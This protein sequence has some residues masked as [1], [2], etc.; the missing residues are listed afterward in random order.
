MVTQGTFCSDSPRREEFMEERGRKRGLDNVAWGLPLRSPRIMRV[1]TGHHTRYEV[2]KRGRRACDLP[3]LL[4]AVTLWIL[5]V[6]PSEARA[7]SLQERIQ[8]Q[9]AIER[10]YHAHQIDDTR[11]FEEAVPRAV[12]ERKVR[13]YLEHSIALD[14]FW[15]SPITSAMLRHEGANGGSDTHARAAS[16]APSGTHTRSSQ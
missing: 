5:A 13:T 9:E 4:I 6:E 2:E 8:A 15:K 14:L 12:L 1:A 16:R 3:Q 7:L 11:R 10:V